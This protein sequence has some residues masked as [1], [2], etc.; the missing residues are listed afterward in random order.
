M[1][2]RY[3]R[4]PR[5]LAVGAML[6]AVVSGFSYPGQASAAGLAT[7]YALAATSSLQQQAG[8]GQLFPQTGKTVSGRFLDYWNTHDGLMQQGYPISEEMQ[9]QSQVDGRTYTVQY[10]ERAVFELHPENPAPYD[11]LLSLVGA[12]Q[13]ASKYP[14]GAPGQQPYPAG[15][16]VLFPETG[17]RLGGLFLDYWNSHGGLMQQGYPVSDL[18]TEVSALDGKTYTVQYFQRAVF[19]YH[20]E[21]QAPYNVLLSQLGTFSFAQRYGAA[22]AGGAGTSTSSGAGSDGTTSAQDQDGD[23]IP[24]TA[25]KCP[26]Q[27]ENRNGIFDSDGCPDTFNDFMGAVAGDVNNF[28]TQ[29]F[30][31]SGKS[32]APPSGIIPYTTPIRTGCGRSVPNNAFYCEPDNTIYYDSNFLQSQ[33][34]SGGD[35]AVAVITA[36]EWGHLV[37]TDLGIMDGSYRSVDIELQ[38]DC[39]AGAWAKHAEQTGELEAGDLQEGAKALYN[40]GDPANVPWF[41]RQA[42]GTPQQREDSFNNGYAQGAQGCP[43][44]GTPTGL[45]QASK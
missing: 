17:H 35:F 22:S 9:E 8:T 26:T 45:V 13:Y 7:A 10:F 1:D 43:I 5:L 21:N 41:S 39:F 12:M 38:A 25:D 36:H 14:S 11:V 3:I 31:A 20:P 27:L 19:E 6:V 24:D 23:G 15:D 32:Y 16:S 29:T 40:A 18:F 37:Q 34:S 44:A 30:A 33:L 28:W 2:K 42:H 4:G